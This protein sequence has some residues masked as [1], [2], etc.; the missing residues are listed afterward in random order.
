MILV[1]GTYWPLVVVGAIPDSP[2]TA[3]PTMTIDEGHLWSG[4]DLRL[5]VV[6]AGDHSRAWVA[7]EEV[8]DWLGRHRDR[9]LRCVSRVAWILEDELMRRNAERWLALVG[10]RLFRGEVT[11]FRSVRSALAWL[12]AD[13]SD[14]NE[15]PSRR[16]E[17]GVARAAAR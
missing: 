10:D 11:T 3:E 6:I 17:P 9:L 15:R 7:Q 2:A 12:S 4:G 13:A 5:A 8:F 14:Q 1:E 16:H